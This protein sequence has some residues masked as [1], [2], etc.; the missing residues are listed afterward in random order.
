MTDTQKPSRDAA[1]EFRQ[2]ISGIDR[3]RREIAQALRDLRTLRDTIDDARSRGKI[4]KRIWDCECMLGSHTQFF[5]QAGQDAFLDRHIFGGKRDGVFVEIGGYDGITGSNCLFFELRRGWRGLV[6]EPAPSHFEKARGARR[7]TCLQLAVAASPGE[8]DF[9]EVREGYSQMS[10]LA[11]SYDQD[12]LKT[13]E[14]NP[15]HKGEVI[16]VETRTLEQIL[17]EQGLAQIDFISLDVE[18]GELAVLSNFP[19]EKYQIHAWTIENNSGESDVPVLMREKGYRRI[20][21]LGADDVY[22][23]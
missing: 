14:K 1:A 7:A 18:G 9:L 2:A 21:A 3:G 11:N 23:R 13:V 5:S 19:F 17:D 22:T 4:N 16:K 12:L 8:A 20:E 15:H 6:I 10:G